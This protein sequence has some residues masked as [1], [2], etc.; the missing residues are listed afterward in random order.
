MTGGGHRSRRPRSG[1]SDGGRRPP[2]RQGEAGEQQHHR[3]RTGHETTGLGVQQQRDPDDD[4]HPAGDPWPSPRRRTVGR[5]HQPQPEVEHEADT[6]RQRQQHERDAD[7]QRVDPET[8]GEEAGDTAQDPVVVDGDLTRRGRGAVGCPAMLLVESPVGLVSSP[9]SVVGAEGFMR[10]T[11]RRPTSIAPSGMS[12]IRSRGLGDG[13]DARSGS[14]V[15]RCDGWSF[16]NR[17]PACR[18]ART[19]WSPAWPAAGP[20]AGVS[21]RPWSG[22]RSGC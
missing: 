16:A 2:Q 9:G 21:S 22:P 20:T 15:R 4:D 11:V 19:G 7:P 3:D 13:P 14:G 8:S 17:S 10:S 5:Q 1:R 6:A 12:L 18:A